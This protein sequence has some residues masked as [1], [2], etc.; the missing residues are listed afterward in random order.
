MFHELEL[1]DDADASGLVFRIPASCRLRVTLQTFDADALALLDAE[2]R[3]VEISFEIEAGL[4]SNDEID[5]VGGRTGAMLVPETA[6]TL[7]LLEDGVEVARR[8]A[9]LVPGEVVEIRL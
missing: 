9:H 7:I 2:G 1:E 3:R 5:L 8:D 4:V 6:K